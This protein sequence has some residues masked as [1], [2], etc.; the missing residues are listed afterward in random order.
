MSKAKENLVLGKHSTASEVVQGIDLSGMEIVVTGGAA[1]LG[2]ETSLALAETGARV[3]LAVRN[4]EQGLE[5]QQII[6]SA[7]PYARVAVAELDLNDIPCIKRFCD[8]WEDQGLPLNILINN[9]AIMA[10]PLSR[11]S[12]G[13]EQQFATNHMGHFALTTSL[14]PALQRAAAESGEARVISLSSIGHKRATVDFSDIH[15][16]HRTYDKWVA[17]GQAKSANALFSRGLDNLF[18]AHGISANAVNPGAILTGL[19]KSLTREEM[20]AMGWFKPDGNVLDIF[21]SPEQGA[22]TTVWAAT[23]RELQGK[24]GLY[25]ED[26]QVGTLA[27]PDNR[28][29]GYAPH[30][31]DDEAASRLW[32]VSQ[33][34]LQG[35][36]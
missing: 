1:G 17:Y 32:S 2:L 4:C 27:G 7:I 31:M 9:A 35:L 26:C 29:S 33:N 24:G 22:A 21:K 25:L 16:Q 14:M 36:I 13:W 8:N 15:F 10:C 30:I 12:Y 23:A 19:Q 28:T 3:T 34:L 11:N 6:Q 20:T 5:V 18:N